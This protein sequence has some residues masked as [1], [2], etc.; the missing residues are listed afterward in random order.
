MKNIIL[1][2]LLIFGLCSQVSA[3]HLHLERTY[4]K[5]WCGKHKGLMEYRLKDGT[6]VDC[7]T[8]DYAIEFDFND[9]WAEAIGQS[10]YYSLM[11]NKKPGIVLISEKPKHSSKYIARVNEVARKYNIKVW[12]MSPT[13]LLNK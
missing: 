5:H 7:L 8:S 12:T 1:I 4:Q 10:L 3:K 13:D 11:T 6:R 2:F 9:K